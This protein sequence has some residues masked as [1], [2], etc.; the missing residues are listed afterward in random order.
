[1]MRRS[2]LIIT[3]LTVCGVMLTVTSVRQRRLGSL[4]N[5]E[6]ELLAQT[7]EVPQVITETASAEVIASRT[8]QHTPSL[9]LLRLRGQV[10]QLERRRRELAGVLNEN[11][12]LRAQLANKGTNAPGGI[13]LPAGYLRK[14]D[15]KF[16]G[17]NTPEATVQTMLW[18]IENRDT[19]RFVEVFNPE[20]A[21][22]ME[23]EIQRR[24]S[25]EEFFKE[26]DAMPGLRIIGREAGTDDT[27]VLLVEMIPGD[28]AQAQKLHFKQITGQW[29]LV[30]G[31]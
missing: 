24:G 12:A 5:Q 19:S 7:T 17:Y 20:I 29:K 30:S 6:R 3:C 22:Q 28:E 11:E 15:A 13:P 26:A 27:T 4:K 21:K 9:E 25:P 14:A 18:A 10:G 2:L 1:M 31:L 16:S 8:Q 23:A